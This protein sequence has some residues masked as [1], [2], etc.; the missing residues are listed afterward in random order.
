[1]LGKLMKYDMK[2][3]AR[4]LP[5]LYVGGLAFSALMT[6]FILV[7]KDATLLF[8]GI[9]ASYFMF[10][11]AVE[12]IS[13]CSSVF[14]MVRIYKNMFSDEGYLTFTLPVKN[15][16]VLNSKIFTGAIWTFI[17]GTVAVVMIAMPIAAASYKLPKMSADGMGFG[18]LI[19]SIIRQFRV[20][21]A[22]NE[23]KL[24]IFILLV[25]ALIAVS[26]FFA[27]A[28]Y[29]FCCAITH[30]IKKA[31]AFASVGIF[32]GVSYGIG[33]VMSIITVIV[34]IFGEYVFDSPGV[35]TVT[36]TALIY[37]TSELSAYFGSRLNIM[38]VELLIVGTVMMTITV[39]S[40]IVSNRIV[41]KK[42]NLL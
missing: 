7:I 36:P 13:V 23:A 19:E 10:I 41:N 2:Y 26:A 27:P 20:G 4:I 29:S 3:M 32:I 6:A 14:M 37:D 17:S 28:F 34:E 33:L 11:I 42:L 25:I 24:I 38:T 15:G 16:D 31:R 5:W 39:V 8:L 12:A 22:G 30:K 9:Y 1:M 18:L 35:N 21:L 40:W